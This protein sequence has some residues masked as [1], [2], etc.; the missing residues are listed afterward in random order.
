[1]Y[2]KTLIN[3]EEDDLL[4]KI[5]MIMTNNKMIL[6]TIDMISMMKRIKRMIGAWYLVL[7]T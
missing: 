1:M 7:C 2:K 3:E 5:A 6:L 4:G